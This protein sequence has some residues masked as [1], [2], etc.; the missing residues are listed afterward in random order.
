M[1][2]RHDIDALRALAF[3]LLILYHWGMLYVGDWGWHIK[4]THTADWLQIPMLVV[5]RWR[6]SLI[7]LISGISSAFLMARTG[8]FAFLG[9]RTWRLLLPLV[10]GMLVIVPV[11]PYVQGIQTGFVKPGFFDFLFRYYE[12]K[13]WPKGAFDGDTNGITWNHL[14]YLA[15]VW[16]FTVALVLVKPLL[17]SRPGLR[18]RAAFT[19]LRGWALLLI[20]AIPI[21]IETVTLQG[22]FEDTGDLVHDGYRDVLYFTMFLYGFWLARSGGVWDELA[23]LRRRALVAALLLFPVYYGL[24]VAL[25]DDA[26][27]AQQ[28]IWALRSVYI[29]WAIA[30]VLGWSKAYLDRP[31]P[32][33]GWA[34]EAV[35]PWYV[36]HQSLIVLLAYWLVPLRLPA[37]IEASAVLIGTVA[38]CWIGFAIIRRV[39]LLRPLFG[40]KFRPRETRPTAST[41]RIAEPANELA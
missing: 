3:A 31:F 40:M 11:Q 13:P 29:W 7:F 26:P 10:F 1:T 41:L 20:P 9:Q 39:P 35:F 16:A 25:P 12:F 38:G 19:G 36:L 4:S 28:L 2:R 15:Y 24:G 23:R 32:W 30:A 34:T 21:A 8:G 22:H 33:L 17:D 5:N 37:G 6:M 14:W 18:V 27:G